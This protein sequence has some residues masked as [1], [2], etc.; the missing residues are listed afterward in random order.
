MSVLSWHFLVMPKIVSH[1]GF[2]AEP[3]DLFPMLSSWVLH[4][5]TI[6]RVLWDV[7]HGSVFTVQVK[8]G[9][10]YPALTP[11]HMGGEDFLPVLLSPFW[12]PQLLSCIHW[13]WSCL[14]LPHTPPPK[15]GIFLG[16]IQ[17]RW[18]ISSQD[19]WQSLLGSSCFRHIILKC[20]FAAGSKGSGRIWILKI[21][22][23]NPFP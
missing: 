20:W 4:F 6:S 19:I 15:T 11:W 7:R 14:H 1:P 21:W 18:R 10:P 2:S 9:F 3:D 13:P 17:P 22:D 8:Q 16:K 23:M 5:L 12:Q